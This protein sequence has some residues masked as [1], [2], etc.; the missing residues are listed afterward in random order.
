MFS[1][2][3]KNKKQKSKKN[4][5][6]KSNELNELKKLVENRLNT[7]I[8]LRIAIKNNCIPNNIPINMPFHKVH[9]IYPPVTEEEILRN[10]FDMSNKDIVNKLIENFG[11]GALEE[12]IANIAIEYYIKHCL[13]G[14]RQDAFIIKGL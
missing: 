10:G 4:K 5:L 1:N 9:K 8:K 13:D 6:L 2:Q 12:F 11:N 7:L 3:K 14:Y